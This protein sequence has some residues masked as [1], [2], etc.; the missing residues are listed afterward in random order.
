M[1]RRAGLALAVIGQ[2]LD[3][4][5]G[6]RPPCAPGTGRIARRL[7]GIEVRLAELTRTRGPVI[8]YCHG[9]Y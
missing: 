9:W 3:I 8:V 7:A 5:D 2:A 6:G 4:R 1:P